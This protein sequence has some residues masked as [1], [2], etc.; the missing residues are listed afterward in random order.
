G[1]GSRR[2]FAD[3]AAGKLNIRLY[4]WRL[5]YSKNQRTLLRSHLWGAKQCSHYLQYF[6]KQSNIY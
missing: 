1:S 6:N 2:T 3:S 5:S 4:D